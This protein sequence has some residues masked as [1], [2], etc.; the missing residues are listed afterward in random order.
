MIIKKK[1]K[2]I[3]CILSAAFWFALM[4]LC[5]RLSGD[6]PSVQK[7]FFRNLVAFFFAAFIL[8][9]EKEWFSGEKGNIK[10]LILR[11]LFGTIGILGNFYAVDHLMLADATMLNKM[12]PFFAIVFS[13]FLLKEKVRPFQIFAVAIAFGGSMLI[14]KPAVLG[15]DIIPAFIGLL[16]G[17]GAGAAYTMV[18]ILGERKEKGA[19]IVFF[20]S[21]F[22]CLVTL[23]FLVWQFHPM[24]FGQTAIL[25]L[26]G[27]CAAGGQFSITA[28]YYYAPAR[29]VS[30]YDYTQV[31]FSAVL[32]YFI[33]GQV[34]DV[35]SW[36]GYLVICGMGVLMFLYQNRWMARGR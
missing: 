9:R 20:F 8:F 4:S 17:I 12:S 1:Y 16:G 23:P 18:R 15:M 25:L 7:S 36:L 21:G 2:G 35:Y 3:L 6:L 5:V 30:V 26:A 10:Y 34:P 24:S 31:V 19:F 14:V 33:F 28:A 27:L 22:S 11:S 32:G 13:Y 29:E